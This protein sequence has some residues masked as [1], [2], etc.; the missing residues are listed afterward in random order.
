MAYELVQ[1]ADRD[2]LRLFD[3]DHEDGPILVPITEL[4][5]DHVKQ[6]VRM[7]PMLGD[8]RPRSHQCSRLCR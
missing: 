7:A 4:L 1:V 8:F 3:K 5:P 2:I 6:V